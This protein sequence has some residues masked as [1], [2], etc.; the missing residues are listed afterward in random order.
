MKKRLFTVLLA[1]AFAVLALSACAKKATQKTA[2]NAEATATDST[3]ASEPKKEELTD[4][5][6]NEVAHSIFYAPMYA[7]IEEGY[8]EKE[9]IRLELVCGFGAVVEVCSMEKA[10]VE[11]LMDDM[12]ETYARAMGSFAGVPEEDRTYL[13][14]FSLICSLSFDVYIK[15]LIIEKLIDSMTDKKED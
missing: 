4:V 7:A 15:K 11:P 6:L 5:T 2:G 12:K 10:E 9:G 14:L 1:A 3:T 13:Q 8:F